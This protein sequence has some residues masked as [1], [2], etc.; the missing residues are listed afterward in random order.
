MREILSANTEAYQ[1]FPPDA[2]QYTLCVTLSEKPLLME[3]QKAQA[4]IRC[5]AF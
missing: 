5:Q 2:L 1:S 4:L 3:G